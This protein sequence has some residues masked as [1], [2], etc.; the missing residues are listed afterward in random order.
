[1]D[2]PRRVTPTCTVTD[3]DHASF[4]AHNRFA[5]LHTSTAMQ[6]S[7]S[8]VHEK[9]DY[10]FDLPTITDHHRNP[11]PSFTTHKLITA[12]KFIAD[13]PAIIQASS[14]SC[15]SAYQLPLLHPSSFITAFIAVTSTFTFTKFI[16]RSF[17][18]F[19]LDL[20]AS[21]SFV[22]RL[23]HLGPSSSA[24]GSLA[25]GQAPFIRPLDPYLQASFGHP[26]QATFS[27]VASQPSLVLVA[28]VP[29]CH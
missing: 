26:Y 19:S 6:A 29:I 25:S 7:T 18:P 23:G 11:Q 21:T 15:L 20:F 8:I 27:L 3:L 13:M 16:L 1:M 4:L 2:P 10:H 24:K 12:R 22:G 17:R 9:L 5:H 28:I 14:N